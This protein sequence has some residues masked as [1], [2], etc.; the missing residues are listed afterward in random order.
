MRAPKRIQEKQRFLTTPEMTNEPSEQ[1]EEIP[2]PLEV[3]EQK[4][5]F[6]KDREEFPEQEKE[7]PTKKVSKR[8]KQSKKTD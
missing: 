6:P 2:Q 5:E 3:P 7:I 1:E 4:E 8:K